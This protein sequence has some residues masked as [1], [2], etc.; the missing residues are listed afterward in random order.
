MAEP[1]CTTPFPLTTSNRKGERTAVWA[2]ALLGMNDS[3]RGSPSVTP[4]KP[5]R[6]WRRL[7]ELSVFIIMATG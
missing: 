1:A 4:P 5:F 3:S 2:R 6:K 7:M